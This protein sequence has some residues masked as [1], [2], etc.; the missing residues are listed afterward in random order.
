MSTAVL[1]AIVRSLAAGGTAAARPTSTGGG[2]GGFSGLAGG[3]EGAAAHAQW[4]ATC[5]KLPLRL[6]RLCSG[7]PSFAAAV[8]TAL[9]VLG[10]D[11]QDTGKIRSSLPAI[12]K[13]IRTTILCTLAQVRSTAGWLLQKGM[14]GPPVCLLPACC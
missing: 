12:T 1:P 2:R 7:Q 11:Y 13:P 8:A 3:S 6:A 10:S 4:R 9:R 14:L 5:R